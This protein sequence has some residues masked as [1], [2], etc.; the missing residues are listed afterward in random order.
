MEIDARA[1]T[2]SPPPEQRPR[3]AIVKTM[4]ITNRWSRVQVMRLSRYFITGLIAV[5]PVVVTL[6]LL[7]WLG[8][9][10]ETILGG[11]IR[12]VVPERIYVPGMGIAAGLA[13]I[14]LVGMLVNAWFFGRLFRWLDGLMNRIPLVKTVYGAL[15][16]LM[17]F[18]G[19]KQAA[20]FGQV[21]AV[22]LDQP[23]VRL[24]GF[25]TRE[26]FTGLPAALGEDD[27]VA[28]YLPM[29]YQIGG[30]MLLVPRAALIPLDMS[31]EE[32]MRFSITAGM[33]MNK[34]D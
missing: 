13:I 23:P 7:W 1:A 15:R 28:V 14:L 5:V 30:Y 27:R 33:S 8:S 12:R 26:D 11:M 22:D 6:A 3:S 9:G 34:P 29:S 25:V 10:A 21:V 24:I 20:R 16:D 2:R 4:H 32:A 19:G 31:L 18:V 17:G